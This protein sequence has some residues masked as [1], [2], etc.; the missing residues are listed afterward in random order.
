MESS[1]MR[2]V[3]EIIPK[4]AYSICD[5]EKEENLR[6]VVPWEASGGKDGQANVKPERLARSGRREVSRSVE[7]GRKKDE[8]E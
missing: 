7:R 2:K 8:K 3:A 4:A 1:K 5:G 6:S